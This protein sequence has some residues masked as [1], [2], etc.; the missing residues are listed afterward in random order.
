[1]LEILKPSDYPQLLRLLGDDYIGAHQIVHLVE[2]VISGKIPEVQI[3]VDKWPEF[4]VVILEQVGLQPHILRKNHYTFYTKANKQQQLEDVLLSHDVIDPEKEGLLIG[5]QEF[6]W[7]VIYKAVEQKNIGYIKPVDPT[8]CYTIKLQ[9]LIVFPVSPGLKLKPI[10][11]D[12]VDIM[13][14]SWNYANEVTPDYFYYLIDHYKTVALYD[15]DDSLIGYMMQTQLG[16]VGMLRILPEKRGKGYSKI[17]LSNLV[18]M[19]FEDGADVVT[20]SIDPKNEISINLHLKTGFKDS[21]TQ[22]GWLDFYPFKHE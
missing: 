12:T 10:P 3:M 6:N 17:I 1:M 4:N 20:S 11:H 19:V 5:L 9:D 22:E 7:N 18:K 16:T 21:L 2:N 8:K 15:V 14:S 13:L